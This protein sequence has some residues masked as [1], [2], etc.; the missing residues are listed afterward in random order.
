MGQYYND[1]RNKINKNCRIPLWCEFKFSFFFISLRVQILI[2]NE[3]PRY[4]FHC[5]FAGTVMCSATNNG[6]KSL[7]LSSNFND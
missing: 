6:A 2:L 5:S 7:E 4:S 1:Y 3:A